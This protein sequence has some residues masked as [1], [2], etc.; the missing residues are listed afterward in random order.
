MIL[1]CAR[2]NIHGKDFKNIPQSTPV[3]SAH[4]ANFIVESLV[5]K[6]VV[7]IARTIMGTIAIMSKIKGMKK[8]DAVLTSGMPSRAFTR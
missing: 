8:L 2:D 3:K 1:R 5:M 6:P 4:V 7:K